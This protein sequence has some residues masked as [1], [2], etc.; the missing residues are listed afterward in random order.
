MVLGLED[1]AF[2]KA[3][4]I[5]VKVVKFVDCYSAVGEFAVEAVPAPVVD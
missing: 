4:A 1:A 2:A 3:A 5:E